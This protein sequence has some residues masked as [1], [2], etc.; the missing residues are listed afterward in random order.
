MGVHFGARRAQY[1]RRNEMDKNAPP[2]AGEAMLTRGFE[3]EPLQFRSQTLNEDARTVDVVFTTGAAVRRSDY[4]T[5]EV[6]DEVLVVSPEAID[7]TRLNAGAPLLANHSTWSLDAVLGVVERAW[8]DGGTGYATVRFDTG[9]AGSEAMRRVREGTLRNVSVG[10]AVDKSATVMDRTQAVPVRRHER[11][12]PM[13]ISLVPVPADAGAQTRAALS[14]PPREVPAQPKEAHMRDENA[15]AGGN[16]PA[17]TETRAAPAGVIETCI[18]AAWQTMA[19]GL[20]QSSEQMLAAMAK[21]I[22]PEAWRDELIAARAAAADQTA[23]VRNAAPASAARD[24]RAGRE[25]QRAAVAEALF[26]RNNP[27]HTP[28]EAARAYCG[29]GIESMCRAFLQATGER[30][31]AVLSK[32]EVLERVM[33]T[34]D[35]PSIFLNVMNKELQGQ[36][37]AFESPLIQLGAPT[38][39]TDFRA[40]PFVKVSEFPSLSVNAEGQEFGIGSLS[41]DRES[42][43]ASRYARRIIIT[44]EMILNDDLGALADTAGMATRAIAEARALVLAGLLTANSGAGATLRDG[45]AAF[46]T[47]RLNIATGGASAL[48]EASLTTAWTGMVKQRNLGGAPIAVVPR[49]LVVPPDLYVAARKLVTQVQAAQTSNVNVFT[50]LV[51]LFDPRLTGA[52]RWWLFAAPAASLA[53]LRYGT[54]EGQL[55]PQFATRNSDNFDGVEMRVVDYF[56]AG[57]VEPKLGFCSAGA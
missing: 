32:S 21:G 14:N 7:L 1:L 9:E 29:M 54:I 27:G 19:R 41:D 20:G 34:G 6:Y 56:G 31:I 49:F 23:P 44:R 39:F 52:T 4:W 55:L 15:A 46:H 57:I 33:A 3:L 8:I 30:G 25:A 28:S 17:I 47:S 38:S 50:D 13:E 42:I 24:E 11:W 48:S 2:V 35:L 51:V 18:L 40:K 5:G 37:A 22:S 26:V 45:N 10:Y 36:W 12:T 53:F 16:D 43:S